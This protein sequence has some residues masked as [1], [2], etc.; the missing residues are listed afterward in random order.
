MGFIAVGY[1]QNSDQTFRNVYVVRTDSVGNTLWTKNIGSIGRQSLGYSV[2]TGIDGFVITG[3]NM[4]CIDSTYS[5]FLTKIDLNGNVVWSHNIPSI[6]YN[7]WLYS[8]TSSDSGGY[9]LAG[10]YNGT[11]YIAKTDTNGNVGCNQSDAQM[12]SSSVS[13]IVTTVTLAQ[14]AVTPIVNNCATVESGATVVTTICSSNAVP[15][16]SDVDIAG[17]PN[18]GKTLTGHYIYSDADGDLEGASTFKWFVDSVATP[19][20]GIVYVIQP[21]DFGKKIQFEVTPVAQ[22]GE[23]VGLPVLSAQLLIIPDGIKGFNTQMVSIYPNPAT[24]TITIENPEG[25]VIEITNI[26]GQVVKTLASTS[27]KTNIDVSTFPSGVYF[28][29]VKTE[30][31]IEVKK[32]IKE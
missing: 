17:S 20:T 29:K 21:S 1:T 7:E 9:V 8:V 27:S 3:Y 14:L 16:V 23:L 6:D 12:V 5:N 24:N 11:V 15:V 19:D 13:T 28:V 10:Q 31:G 22:T 4:H 2:E 25:A 26:Q 18:V 30:I 32:F